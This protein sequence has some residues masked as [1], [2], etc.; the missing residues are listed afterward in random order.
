[1]GLSFA[2][3]AAEL[4]V[5]ECPESQGNV[6]LLGRWITS[7]GARRTWTPA[8]RWRI[9]SLRVAGPELL[10]LAAAPVRAEAAKWVTLSEPASLRAWIDLAGVG[11]LARTEGDISVRHAI[12]HD[13]AID[14]AGDT[15]STTATASTS[16]DLTLFPGRQRGLRILCDGHGHQRV[17]ISAARS[18]ASARHLWLV[19]RVVAAFLARL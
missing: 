9:R 18:S 4:T 7:D 1:L 2:A 14:A 16:T 6:M 10:R 8:G 19:H 11:K 15:L 17:P 3:P 5:A 12:A 13:V